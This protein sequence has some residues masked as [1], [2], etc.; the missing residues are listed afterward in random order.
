MQIMEKHQRAQER[1]QLGNSRASQTPDGGLPGG[2]ATPGNLIGSAAEEPSLVDPQS[3]DSQQPPK[4]STKPDPSTPKLPYNFPTLP[5]PSTSLTNPTASTDLPIAMHVF[6][7][8]LNKSWNPPANSSQKAE[9][10]RG[11][12]VVQGLV[13][14]RGSR[15]RILFDVQSCYDPRQN[16]YVVVNAAVRGFKRWNQAPRGGP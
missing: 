14:V 11:S 7:A 3:N 6:S 1:K 5:L 15:G 12:F 8:S 10:P 9:P 4:S 2:S 13:E 16:K